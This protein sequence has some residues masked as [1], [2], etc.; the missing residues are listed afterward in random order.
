VADS[1]VWKLWNWNPQHQFWSEFA[2]GTEEEV[3]AARV[4]EGHAY[5]LTPPGELPQH[6]PAPYELDPVRLFVLTP[7]PGF[8]DP[9]PP[10]LPERKR[11]LTRDQVV[12]NT[13]AQ[14]LGTDQPEI[15]FPVI[16]SHSHVVVLQFITP[17]DRDSFKKWITSGDGW[18]RFGDW[19]DSQ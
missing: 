3:R 4:Q 16:T 14:A 5:V 8:T 6:N 1:G 7:T 2:Q 10:R 13:V 9:Y 19:W 11:R 18:E 17:E 15:P 12:A